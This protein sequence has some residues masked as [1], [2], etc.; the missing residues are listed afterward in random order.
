M[1]AWRVVRDGPPAVALSLESVAIPEPGPGQARIRVHTTVC[2]YNEVDGCYGRYRTVRPSLPYTLGMEMVG[3]VDAVGAGVDLRLGERVTASDAGAFGAHAQ[4]AVVD[5]AMAFAVPEQLDDVAGSAFF[6]PFHV[7]YLALFE[8]GR[9]APGETLLVHAGAGGVGSAAV[10]LGVAAGARVIATAGS[11]EKVEFCRSLGAHVAINYGSGDF[12][13]AVLEAT[14]GRGVDVVCDLVG[15]ATTTA[16]FPVMANG[17][18]LVMAGFSGG[19][20]AEDDALITPRPIIFGNFAL[21]GVLLSYR[22]G[23][24]KLGTVNV[25]SRQDGDRVHRA[26]VGLLDAGLIRTVVG[27]V[28]SYRDLPA[29]LERLEARAVMGRSVLDWRPATAPA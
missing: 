8:R 16:T 29:E 20:E 6:F 7:G 3:V 5:A 21:G 24:T 9:L 10:Q 11:D 22:S 17:G 2:N 27:R 13:P 18:R 26:L 14:G 12:G 25:F 23:P 15:G 19:I 1:L 4:F 28:S